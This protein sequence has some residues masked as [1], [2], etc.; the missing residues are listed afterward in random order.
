MSEEKRTAVGAGHFVVLADEIANQ[1]GELVGRQKLRVL[2]FRPGV[3]DEPRKS[4]RPAK[5]PNPPRHQGP[6]S[7]CRLSRSRSP[8]H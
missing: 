3:A 7:S 6:G 5:H 2:F 4:G 1:K 8:P